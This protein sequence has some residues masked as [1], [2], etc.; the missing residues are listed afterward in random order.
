MRVLTRQVDGALGL[1]IPDAFAKELGISPN[2]EVWVSRMG[3]SIVISLPRERNRLDELLSQVT[4]SN[5]HGEIDTGPD[6]GR[7]VV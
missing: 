2:S 3:T 6:V 5:L 1:T 4:E 7:E